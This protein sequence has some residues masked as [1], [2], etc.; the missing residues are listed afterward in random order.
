MPEI[1]VALAKAPQ[2]F[3]PSSGA[4][5]RTRVRV[6]AFAP[7]SLTDAASEK[8]VR[9]EI[10]IGV[11]FAVTV[12]DGVPAFAVA[13]LIVIEPPAGAVASSVTSY[14][15]ALEVPPA[16]LVA[17][18]VREVVG[19]V[20]VTSKVTPMWSPVGVTVKFAPPLVFSEPK[21]YD[22]TP[23]CASVAAA[24]TVNAPAA[25]GRKNS[26][27][28]PLSK[29]FADTPVNANVGGDGVVASSFTIALVVLTELPTLSS[30]V[31]FHW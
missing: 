18:A 26:R 9:P 10:V 20:V 7:D 24:V 13:P 5:V 23:V 1:V 2:L 4:V 21:L 29:A 15:P 19:P 27:P 31:S 16:L 22:A 8:F 11:E 17:V 3:E 28:L 25:D 14:V 30:P 6:E 12:C